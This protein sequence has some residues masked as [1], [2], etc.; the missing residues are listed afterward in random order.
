M[1]L[2]ADRNIN[3]TADK[4]VCGA[5]K[6]IGPLC[7]FFHWPI[8]ISHLAMV[9][10]FK[11]HKINRKLCYCKYTACNCLEAL[12]RYSGALNYMLTSTC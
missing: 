11:V 10:T 3:S 7:F 6:K 4:V 12:L 2:I 1:K 8:V 9:P 5:V